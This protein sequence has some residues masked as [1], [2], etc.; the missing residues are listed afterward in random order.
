MNSM[1]SPASERRRAHNGWWSECHPNVLN[2]S[3]TECVC[4]YVGWWIWGWVA[5]GLSPR[6]PAPVITIRR[7]QQTDCVQLSSLLSPL[8]FVH[9]V[10][11]LLHYFLSPDT[12]KHLSFFLFISLSRL[13]LFMIF[14][15]HSSLRCTNPAKTQMSQMQIN[16]KNNPRAWEPI[17]SFPVF[18]LRGESPGKTEGLILAAKT[19]GNTVEPAIA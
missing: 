6:H 9:P 1:S 3:W 8:P 10:L 11:S 14:T 4:V 19:Q 2:V 12:A 18:P 5:S 17:F 15:F 16:N 7:W 13:P